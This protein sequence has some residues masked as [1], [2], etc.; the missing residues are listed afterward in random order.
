MLADN[1]IFINHLK[2]GEFSMAVNVVKDLSFSEFYLWYTGDE[3]F[4][5]I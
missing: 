1:K 5:E 4:H 3:V 2:K